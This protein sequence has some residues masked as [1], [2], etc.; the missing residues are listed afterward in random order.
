MQD[1]KEKWI[2]GIAAVVVVLG[3]ILIAVRA[4]AP[5]APSQ[6]ATSTGQ[7]SI[8][9]VSARDGSNVTEKTPTSAAG[10]VRVSAP[11]S[12]IVRY[13]ASGFQPFTLTVPHGQSVEFLNQSNKAMIIHSVEQPIE[14]YYPGFEQGGKPLGYGGKFYFTF[15]TPGVWAYQ[16]L[17]GGSDRG[18]IIVR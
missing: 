12:Y 10:G 11:T 7:V 18:V 9:G 15:T 16:N 3:L 14:S 17:D 1:T 6:T 5:A 2:W 4:G 13:T 8:A